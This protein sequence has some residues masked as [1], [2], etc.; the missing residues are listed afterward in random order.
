MVD[1]VRRSPFTYE[2]FMDELHAPAR[3]MIAR[4]R[5]LGPLKGRTMEEIILAVG[6]PN[7]VSSLGARGTVLQWMPHGF[8]IVLLFDGVGVCEGMTHRFVAAGV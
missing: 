2:A 8:H 7:S 1:L 5:E 4:F 3:A 6:E